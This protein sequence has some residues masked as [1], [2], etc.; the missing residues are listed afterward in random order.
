MR[1]V[2][3]RAYN[4]YLRYPIWFVRYRPSCC[5]LKAQRE[6]PFKER[7]T[8]HI[9]VPVFN[10][11]AQYLRALVRSVRKQSYPYWVLHLSDGNSTHGDTVA[12]LASVSEGDVRIRVTHHKD[13]LGISGNTNRAIRE[14]EDGYIVFSD[15]DDILA[16]NA[17]YE[18]AQAIEQTGADFLYSDEDHMGSRGLRFDMPHFKPDFSPDRLRSC[19]YICH[20]SAVKLELARR[21]GELDSTCDGSQDHDYSLRLAEEAKKIVHIPKVL[22]HW[23]QFKSSMSAQNSRRCLDAGVRAVQ[24][25]LERQGEPGIVVEEAGFYRVSYDI[26]KDTSVSVIMLTRGSEQDALRCGERFKMQAGANVYEIIPARMAEHDGVYAALNAAAQKAQGEYLLFTDESVQPQSDGFVKELLMHAQR[27][28]RGVAG[29]CIRDA[30]GCFANVGYVVGLD[31]TIAESPLYGT[32]GL[33]EYLYQGWGWHAANVAALSRAAMMIRRALFEQAGGFDECFQMDLGDVD[34]CI[35]LGNI[36]YY[37][38]YTPYAQ[39]V[40]PQKTGEANPAILS[41]HPH[42]QDAA[43]FVQKWGESVYDPFYPQAFSRADAR[44]SY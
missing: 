43:Y 42:A 3:R 33:G 8:F 15:H 9:V 18:L 4:T 36:G 12:C 7:V 32:P 22:Y 27:R 13:N 5:K 41:G 30:E 19:N 2:I 25:Q 40:I 1:A 44:F 21:V 10:T 38:V 29:P 14:V 16:P 31:K 23:R 39:A 26:E 6:Q 34:L 24:K 17:L 28:V 35:R 37:H 20:L 11:K